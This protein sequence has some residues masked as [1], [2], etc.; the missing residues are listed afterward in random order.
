MFRDLNQLFAPAEVPGDETGCLAHIFEMLFD[1]GPSLVFLGGHQGQVLA[2]DPVGLATHGEEIPPLAAALEESLKTRRCC[3]FEHPTRSGTKL[4]F[5]VR[6]SPATVGCVLGG[7]VL[8]TE[9]AQERLA[10]L[11]PALI[12]CGNLAWTALEERS[13]VQRA[14]ARKD[15]LRIEYETLRS[16][17]VQTLAQ[18][19][20]EQQKRIE[21]ERSYAQR[22]EEEVER[23]SAELRDALED[24]TRKS[25]ELQEYSIS[26][27]NA[28]LALE[29]LHRAAQAASQAKT[30]F[31]ASV[32]HELRTPLTAILGYCELLMDEAVGNEKQ[33]E[34]L[35]IVKRNGEHLLEVVNNL[36]DLSKLEAGGAEAAR[37]PCAVGELVRDICARMAGQAKSKGI[38][39]TYQL[40]DD[41]PPTL[42]TDP[43][44]LRQ[45]LLNLIS[46][47]IKF[48]EQ[49]SVRVAARQGAGPE[50]GPRL[51]LEVTDTGIGIPQQRLA[52][53]FEP[54]MADGPW[55]ACTGK[56][57]H[58]GLAVSK[59]LAELLGGEIGVESEPGKGSTFRVAIPLRRDPA[60]R[61]A[62]PASRPTENPAPEPTQPE[63]PA[64]SPYNLACKILLVE[65]SSDNQRFLAAVLRIAGAT[66]T[67]V[68]NGREAVD[69]LCALPGSQHSPARSD[70]GPFDLIL[71][72]MQMPQMDGYTATR[73]L[74][75]SGCQT[76]IIALT[77]RALAGDR[78]KCLAA[79][80]DD[81]LPKPVDR[82][83][84]L[85]LV[86]QYV[87]RE[88]R[89]A[90]DQTLAGDGSGIPSP[91]PA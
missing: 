38:S 48:T 79:G 12:A 65:D 8:S 44:C 45:I 47:A 32:S 37:E 36:L 5:G 24:A 87:R 62:E 43:N 73:I 88:F 28:N 55:P 66:V 57:M 6:L 41:L 26:L 30:Q 68:E 31:L 82:K 4:A 19:L 72:D 52:E 35:Q 91:A 34:S 60:P 50:N 74:R 9:T 33:F 27:E 46:N 83:K 69:L 54:F 86:A 81:Y 71:M 78:E 42:A 22:L 77:A 59:R 56:G 11:V 39:L 23:R 7:L 58:L 1:F 64:P 3:F 80:C 89:H 90:P 63:T 13:A 29:E 84:L 51:V 75:E 49:G 20:E 76:P 53:I 15:Q 21:A 25:L 70:Q 40:A 14:L 18:V 85:A 16:A 10:A 2:A 67:T 17:H 61:Q